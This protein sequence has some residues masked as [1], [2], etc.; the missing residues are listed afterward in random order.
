MSEEQLER[1]ISD[2]QILIAKSDRENTPRPFKKG[3]FTV[4]AIENDIEM[5][6]PDITEEDAILIV[7][8]LNS[9]GINAVMRE[10]I[11]CMHC[12]ERIPKQNFCISCRKKL[13]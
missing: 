11:I 6:I 1:Y 10:S 7:S 9:M 2:L 5:D 4:S 3:A 8:E 13:T 12:K